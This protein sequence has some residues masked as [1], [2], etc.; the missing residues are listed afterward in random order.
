MDVKKITDLDILSKKVLVRADLDV[1]ETLE[2]GDDTKLLTNKKTIDYLL[3]N[4]ARVILMSHRGRP[5]GTVNGKLSMVPVAKRLS[6]LLGKEIKTTTDIVGVEAHDDVDNLKEGEI[7]V[8]E[9]LRFDPREEKNDEGFAKSLSELADIYIN[10]AFSSSAKEHASIVSVP[11]FIPHGLGFHFLEEIENLGKVLNDPKRPVVVLISGIKKDK[12]EYVRP[13]SEFADK[14]LIAGRL[15]EIIDP[16]GI[17]KTELDDESRD[18]ILKLIEKGKVIVADL[19]Q[20]KEDI[21]IH[22]IERFEEDIKKAGTV[23]IGGPIGKFEDDGHRQGTKRVF[24]AA[25]E[26]SAFKV[27]GGGDTEQA[28]QALGLLDKFDWISV[29]GGASLEFLAKGSLPGIDAVS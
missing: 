23:M 12:L 29:G 11:K 27:A 9:N 19:I 15:P 4:K 6:E 18:G 8:L 26:S 28:I 7:L 5:G 20:D 22:S 21:T 14:I 2:E 10:E 13:F 24:E 1:G 25:A 17:G 16:R 3:E